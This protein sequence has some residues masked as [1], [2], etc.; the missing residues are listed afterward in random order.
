MLGC[1]PGFFGV[2][3]MRLVISVAAAVLLS[4]GAASAGDIRAP[5]W[6]GFYI[7]GNI[8]GG[9]GHSNVHY[10]ANDPGSLALF[11][12]VPFTE[13][14]HF[15]NRPLG[16]LQAGY[17]FQFNPSWV[18][19]I[20]ADFNWTGLKAGSGSS[21]LNGLITTAVNQRIESFG[22]VRGR[23]GY[24]PAPNLL[25]FVT[26]GFA[27]AKVDSSATYSVPILGGAVVI[28]PAF[29]MNCIGPAVCA[30]GSSS[31]LVGGWT[32]GG[33]FEYAL[34]QNWTIKAEYLYIHLDGNALTETAHVF[35]PGTA[36]ISFNADFRTDLNILRVGANYR[37]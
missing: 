5:T 6:T 17:N 12:A 30:S 14:S 26:G 19:G 8:G 23:L 4:A 21:G 9:Q 16:G 7:G 20:E 27:Y 36:P 29:S 37:F 25:V 22:T 28:A 34:W 32:I 15:Q 18:I 24:L 3:F 11:E 31:D 10:T 13:R 2:G 35:L 1:C 33:G